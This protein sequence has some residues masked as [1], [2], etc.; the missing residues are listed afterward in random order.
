M[1][2]DRRLQFYRATLVDDGYQ[3]S[4]VFAPIGT[5]EPAQRAD[6]TTR[7]RMAAQQ[8]Q[9][10]ITTRF[11]V[12]STAF[13]RNITARDKIVCEGDT[14]DIEGIRQIDRKRWLEI[15][16]NARDDLIIVSA[17]SFSDDFSLEFA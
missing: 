13:T 16:A 10:D 7:E 6:L 8:V 2:L 1:R 5:G 9:A 17:E 14:F 12:R 4:E 3:Q 15:T 11:T